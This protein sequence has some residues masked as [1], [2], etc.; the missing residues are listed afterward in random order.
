[1][2]MQ[3]KFHRWYSYSPNIL[4]IRLIRHIGYS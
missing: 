3:S 4:G 1:M 2:C